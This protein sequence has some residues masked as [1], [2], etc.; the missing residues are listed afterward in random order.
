MSEPFNIN[1]VLN[2]FCFDG[3]YC[4]FEEKNE[5]NINST[6]LLLFKEGEKSKKYI[7]QKINTYV[8]KDPDTL[9]KNIV[10]VTSHIRSR[11]G[12]QTLNFLE[13]KDGKY[14]CRDENGGCWRCY[15]YIDDVYTLNVVES[16]EVF[17][18][19][20]KA[21]GRFQKILSDYPID[22]LKETIPDFHN[23]YLRFL[24]FKKAVSDNAAGRKDEMSD[25]IAYLLSKESDTKR[26]VT[27]AESGFL[28]LRVTHNDTKLNNI[29]F[30]K[31][32]NEGVCIIDLDTVMPGLSLYDFGD[33]IRFGASTAKE[34]EE[35][36]DKVS[37]N[38]DLFKAYSEG[39]LSEAV[40]SLTKTEIELL[41]YSAYIMTLE[42][43]L[44]FL[45]DYLNGD[46]YFKTDYPAHNKVRT[47]AQIKLCRDIEGKLP[48]MEK[49]IKE[50]IN[51]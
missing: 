47:R 50:I 10:S 32:T 4:G 46:V 45:T 7:L 17:Y 39:Y 20:G 29:L 12:M 43:A 44:R 18:S 14:Y 30:S 21:F 9:M 34:D 5:G 40:S 25:E 27:L 6:F 33:S 11:G 2:C 51:A 3:R 26:L 16:P 37:L 31:A 24:A 38:L 19:S 8:F 41:P 22:E 15:E 13:C 28:P 42:L 36:T 48:L 1:F 35:D 49:T 23:T